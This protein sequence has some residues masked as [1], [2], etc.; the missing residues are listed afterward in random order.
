MPIFRYFAWTGLAL[1]GVLL[2]VSTVLG[3][4]ELKP[5]GAQ[6]MPLEIQKIRA[7]QTKEKLSSAKIGGA[8]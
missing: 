8:S 4:A 3:P 6:E 7:E 1:C 2:G 5:S